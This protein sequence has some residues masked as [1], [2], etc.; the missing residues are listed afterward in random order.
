MNNIPNTLYHVTSVIAA[1][2]I[3]EDG[4]LD[5]KCSQGKSNAV[6][7]CTKS[8]VSYAIAHCCH[9]HGWN[10]PEVCVVTVKK[11][12]HKIVRS[13]HAS[14]FVTR[15]RIDITEVQSAETWL[16][17]EEKYVHIKLN[18]GSRRIQYNE[19]DE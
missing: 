16:S 18:G 19:P 17:R 11:G 2:E 14:I 6:W 1:M 9:R 3:I 4:Y 7:L 13:N 12:R 15:W 5:P 8:K 10:V